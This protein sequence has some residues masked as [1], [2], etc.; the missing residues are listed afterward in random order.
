MDKQ[1]QFSLSERRLRLLGPGMRQFY[2][3]PFHPVSGQGVWLV[4]G[5]GKRYLDAYNNVPHVGHCN[6]VV[7]EALSRQA[8]AL[9]TNTRYLH[10]TILDYAERLL[11]TMPP[12]LDTCMFVCTG[13]EANDLAWRLARAYTGND[14][15]IATR[16]AYHGNSTFVSALDCSTRTPERPNHWLATVPAPPDGTSPG[17]D[18]DAYAGNFDAAIAAL[19]THGH[20]PAAFYMDSL[21]ATDGLD[22]P[23]SGYLDEALRR[24]RAVGGLCVA[25]EVQPGLGRT[26]TAMWGFQNFGIVPD[27]VTTGKPMGNGHPLAVLVTRREIVDAFFAGDRYFNTFGGNPVSAA[28]GLAVLD[29][30]EH[31]K[32]SDNARVV[33]SY[34]KDGLGK[35][36]ADSGAIGA[37]KG[38]GLFLGVAIV[39]PVS[40]QPDAG[41]AR[42][43]I[44]E[45]C[46][47][48]VL[49]G[50]TGPAS[51]L[52][53]IR[54]PMVF[55][56]SDADFLIDTLDAVL[57][58]G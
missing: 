54:P 30:L 55:A 19:A 53:K 49:I 50:L 11:A 8:A 52:L 45:M 23:A 27:I 16:H 14:G 4:D 18:A 7:V 24:L 35:L 31:E 5:E 58:A 26:G 46:R 17:Q 3:F 13:T 36:A 48:G 51:N 9:N 44:N 10:E 32:L 56:R 15:A 1:D 29:V 25:D 34:L 43:I 57:K 42:R 38:A 21:F 40:G 41:R 37:V 47:R 22:L 6:G 2:D 39:D 12:G 28:V 20:R 33:G